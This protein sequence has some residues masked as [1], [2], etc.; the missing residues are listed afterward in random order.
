[1]TFERTE[2]WELRKP[3]LSSVGGI[4]TAQH[5][6]AA[7]V[8][9]QVLDKGGNAVDAAV[10]T[11]LALQTCEPW[12]SGLAAS[13]Y[14]MVREPAGEVSV[15][16]FTGVT[17]AKTNVAAYPLDS[18]A[19][20]SFLG[21]PAVIGNRNVVGWGAVCVPGAVAG[22][23]AALDRFGTWGWDAVLAPTI[24]L[25]DQGLVVDWHT[26]LAIALAAADLGR[27]AAA[28]ALFMPN[29]VPPSPGQ[30]LPFTGL[31]ETLRTLADHGPDAFYKGPIGAAL[32]AD[33]RDGG[34]EITEDDLSAY[35]PTIAPPQWLGRSLGRVAV[36]PITSGGQRLID[37]LQA[38]D[39]ISVGADGFVA[40]ADAL[41]TA[42]AAHRRRLGHG[43]PDGSSTTHLNVVDGQ[44]RV[45]VITFTLLNRFGARVVSPRTG[46]LMNNGMAWFDPRPGFANSL[47]AAKRGANNMCP[48]IAERPDGSPW[49]ALGASGGNQI[50]PALAQLIWF[51][52]EGQQS[53]EEAMHSPRIDTGFSASVRAYPT[54][55]PA[56]VTALSQRFAVTLNQPVVFPRLYA[57]PSGIEVT[58][59]GMRLG[60]AE[61]GYPSAGMVGGG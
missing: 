42:F 31:A 2:Q 44:G 60:Q 51:L 32:V 36:P 56:I 57:S 58:E 21:F 14:C 37:T 54:L 47:A 26:T 16:D 27:D 30:R 41:Q 39:G 18:E 9:G 50:V 19:G 5:W 29:G 22:L 55:D 6:R 43:E 52:M 40:M 38:M 11:A 25:V 28:S 12:M 46:M 48:V 35:A 1:M 34:S 10:A 4:V 23:S 53:I 45:A 15:I 33:A 3:A 13:G 24:D 49:F 61:I 7:Q 20:S 59:A 17:P 8:G